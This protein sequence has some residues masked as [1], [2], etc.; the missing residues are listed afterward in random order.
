M[1]TEPIEYEIKL[2]PRGNGGCEW[3]LWPKAGGPPADKGVAKDAPEAQRKAQRAKER[4]EAK[5]A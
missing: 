5:G 4:L 1:Q 2:Y 3:K